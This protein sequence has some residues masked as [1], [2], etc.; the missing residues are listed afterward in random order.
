[1]FVYFARK[2]C[3]NQKKIGGHN[4]ASTTAPVAAAA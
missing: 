4:K 3:E 1:M 2:E